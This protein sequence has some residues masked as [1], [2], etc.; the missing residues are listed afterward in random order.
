MASPAT[1]TTAEPNAYA[2]LIAEV[3]RRLGT[4]NARDRLALPEFVVGVSPSDLIFEA[5]E[6][7]EAPDAGHATSE[8]R[9]NEEVFAQLVNQVPS[10][11]VSFRFDGRMLWETYERVLTEK[12]LSTSSAQRALATAVLFQQALSD[13]QLAGRSSVGQGDA[14]RYYPTGLLPPS[15]P[16]EDGNWSP[17]SLDEAD[18]AR[19]TGAVDPGILTW[20]GDRGL[21]DAASDAGL[22]MSGLS[23]DLFALQVSRSWLEPRVFA[24]RGWTW[25]GG[26]LSDGMTPPA[27]ELPGY[28]AGLVLAR[29]LVIELR[30]RR[31]PAIAPATAPAEPVAAA[32]TASRLNEAIGRMR[33]VQ[34]A[35]RPA[36]SFRAIT[37]RV[38]DEPGPPAIVADFERSFPVP[39]RL[40]TGPA[41][42]AVTAELEPLEAQRAAQRAAAQARRVEV[43]DHRTGSQGRP[44]PRDVTVRD[45]R[46]GAPGQP[47]RESRVVVRPP[48]PT[49]A[50]RQQDERI[51]VLQSR[52]AELRALAEVA[53]DPKATYVLAF[54]WRPLPRC[55][56]PDPELFPAEG[57][58]ESEEGS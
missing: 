13:L 14:R 35:R 38:R 4:A 47:R 42:A 2:A 50:Q 36:A 57:S 41:L 22:A 16:A 33:K 12:R 29:N 7:A 52:A 54:R 51:G 26:Q 20:L 9:R 48:R 28:V 49:A 53:P 17:V 15:D 3:A 23:V 24:D 37:V 30:P 8:A 43:R 34:A 18:L 1:G 45:H 25:D 44:P 40:D 32:R 21:L 10:G 27:G 58:V 39:A 55:P 11:E 46:T 6:V 31:T 19:L 5:S 56:D